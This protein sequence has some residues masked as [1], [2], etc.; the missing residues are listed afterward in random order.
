MKPG[1]YSL[2]LAIALTGLSCKHAPRTQPDIPVPVTVIHPVNGQLAM[3]LSSSGIISS[4]DELDLSFKTGGIVEK[5]YAEPGEYIHKG[6]LLAA[7]NTT[8]LVSQ[9]QQN[10]L[11]IEKLTRDDGRLRELSKDSVATLEDLQNNTT[12]L[13]VANAV[14]TTTAYNL[15]QSKLYAPADGIILKKSVHPGEFKSPG[16]A[17]YTIG[18]NL[19]N[20]HWVFRANLSDQD[21]IRLHMGQRPTL[22]LDALPADTFQGKVVRLDNVPDPVTG[23]YNCY[24]AFEPGTRSVVYGMSGRLSIPDPAAPAGTILPVNALLALANNTGRIIIVGTDSLPS[25]LTVHIV[26]VSDDRALLRE[27]LPSSTMVVTDGRNDVNLGKKVR[28]IR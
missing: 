9:L 19:Q 10:Q 22:T 12:N 18:N 11:N 21:R 27:S 20:L 3:P 13:S 24:I 16:E 7:L 8:E 23:I 5:I 6:Q 28:I 26:R 1:I 2:F 14:K 17:V 15:Q 25:S 4:S